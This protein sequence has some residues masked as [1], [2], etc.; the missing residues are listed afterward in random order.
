MLQKHL[1]ATGLSTG[2]ATYAR[3][4]FAAPI[5]AMALAVLVI[6]QGDRLPALPLAFWAWAMAGGV[7]Q[8]VATFAT[9][10]LFSRK[11][12]AV[13]IAF[14]KTEALI[15]A[16]LSV[17]LLSEPVSSF[18]LL[19][20]LIGTCGVLLLSRPAGGWMQGGTSYHALALGL[21]AGA[22][23]G[24]SA[25]GYRAATIAVEHPQAVFRA[26]VALVAA[27]GFQTLVMTIWLFLAEP[28]QLRIVAVR[29]RT[30]LPV[31]V[32][33]VLGSLGWFTAFALQ[34]AAYVRSLGQVEL[35]FS[36]LAS[37][38]VFRERL[39]MIDVFGMLLLSVSVVMI[40]SM[41]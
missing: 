21:I 27:T 33:G 30:V 23:F 25:I 2:G 35:L 31:G 13:G 19:A 20:I 36:I 9:V 28:G 39:R 6:V 4:L 14:T 8:I 29:W 40:V 7:A 17:L 32:T 22:L 1:K 16:G 41:L 26:L 10:A 12:F 15:V 24:A 5:A 34:N 11:S 3:F 18:G 37:V 38:I